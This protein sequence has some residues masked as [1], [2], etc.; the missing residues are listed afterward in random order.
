AFQFQT[1][2]K[3][4]Y[5]VEKIIAQPELILKY[6]VCLRCHSLYL[7]AELHLKISEHTKCPICQKVLTKAIRGSD[8]K[9]K[10]K[11]QMIYP[12]QSIIT[13]IASILADESNERLMDSPFKRQIENGVLG[14]IYDGKVW[15]EF[16]DE[17]GQPFFVG[18][19]TD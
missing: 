17:Q 2:P 6:I 10:Y 8:G 19:K 3:S 12:Y 4:Q 1:F 7:P 5:F 18:D 14:D 13:R 16:L 11:P 9:L 15:Q